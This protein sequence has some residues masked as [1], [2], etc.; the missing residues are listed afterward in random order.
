VYTLRPE[1]YA[2]IATVPYHPHTMQRSPANAA[3]ASLAT[4]LL[5]AHG[6][7]VQEPARSTRRAPERGHHAALSR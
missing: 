6:A 4:A 1:K 3:F 7:H 5:L 2:F